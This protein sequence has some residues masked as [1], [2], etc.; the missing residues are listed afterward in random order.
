M[1]GWKKLKGVTHSQ[2]PKN[3]YY[4]RI[5][6]YHG[7]YSG[8][9]NI[10]ILFSCHKIILMCFTISG[11]NFKSFLTEL[12][13]FEQQKKKKNRNTP[14]SFTGYFPFF[15]TILQCFQTKTLNVLKNISKSY[16]APK[17]VGFFLR[18]NL[19]TQNYSKQILV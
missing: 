15:H 14:I 9:H 2:V 16:P 8:W 5:V 18:T 13:V 4:R 19:N 11:K 12:K 17:T 3:A 6:I 10:S 7:L 1:Y